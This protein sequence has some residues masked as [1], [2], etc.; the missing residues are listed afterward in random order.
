MAQSDA[1]TQR[2]KFDRLIEFHHQPSPG[3]PGE[4]R[5]HSCQHNLRLPRQSAR[6]PTPLRRTHARARYFNLRNSERY[7]VLG[8]LDL[9][10]VN[11]ALIVALRY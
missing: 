3:L 2:G 6:L 9:L 7:V 8:V 1:V 5:L 11:I 10:L 4:R